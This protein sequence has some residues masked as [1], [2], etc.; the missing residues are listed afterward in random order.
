[1][2][3]VARRIFLTKGIGVHKEKLASFEMALR[4]ANIAEFNIVRV[5][6]IFPPKCKII[7]KSQGL[8]HLNAGQVL[9]CVIAES[10]TDEPYRQIASSIGIA[11]P[12]DSSVYGY[13]SEVHTYGQTEQ[14][15]GDY[16]EDLAAQ[17]LA[18][19]LGVPFN[20]DSSWDERKEN[21]KIS[22]EIVRTMNITETAKGD[23]NRKW[24]T[25]IS[26]A[27]LIP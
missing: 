23:R 1:L 19:I 7:P 16:A 8:K 17:M 20:P 24:T 13:L 3:Y 22:D 26:A 6:S 25:V 4:N 18:T 10:S 21:W 14:Q 27:V 9:H 11:I 5:S 15:A 12:K 2:T